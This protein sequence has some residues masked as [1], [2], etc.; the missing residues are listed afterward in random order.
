MEFKPCSIDERDQVIGLS[1]RTFKPNMKEQFR[2]LFSEDNIDHMMIAKDGDRVVSEVNYYPSS[3]I[4][5]DAEIKV[6][7]I[8]SVCTH[9]DY[10]GQSLASTLLKMAE[11][12]MLEEHI[13]LAIIS[14][15]LNIYQRFGARDV[16]VMH[17]YVA[18]PEAKNV[19][20]CYT[21]KS[22]EMSDLDFMYTV[23]YN[24]PIR[25]QRS[26]FEFEEL[27]LGQT[28]PDTYCTYPIFLILEG[29]TPVAYVILSVYKQEQLIKVKEFAGDR[30]AFVD[31]I[32]TIL[33]QYNKSKI[34]WVVPPMDSMNTINSRYSFHRIT[35]KATLKII[36]MGHFFN[37]I[38]PYMNNRYPDVVLVD[39]SILEVTLT[40]KGKRLLL[41]QEEAL[42]LVFNGKTKL[43]NKDILQFVK[44]CFPL[45]M[46]WSHNISYQ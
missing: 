15:D 37:A 7:S 6:A 23:Y 22:F 31:V 18:H 29:K 20:T 30:K 25:Y 24:E 27:L 44:S 4:I 39:S 26:R 28:Y 17:Q 2:R 41:N 46:P 3:I 35:Q 40:I 14:G 13:S 34:T 43:R 10:R 33:K 11:N 5:P 42:N 45:P 32:Q 16:G 21:L 8:G 9:H 19:T 36:H 1:V 38:Q 12:K